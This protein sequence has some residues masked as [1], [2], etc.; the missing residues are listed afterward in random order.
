MVDVLKKDGWYR[1]GSSA[2][3]YQWR[4]AWSEADATEFSMPISGPEEWDAL[5]SGRTETQGQSECLWL[6][7]GVKWQ[8]EMKGME[9]YSPSEQRALLLNE[10][11]ALADPTECRRSPSAGRHG[12]VCA[13][14]AEPW[15][16]EPDQ[17][18]DQA[19]SPAIGVEDEMFRER[20]SGFAKK[21]GPL[22]VG[23]HV[24]LEGH[25]QWY[26]YGEAYERWRTEVV[27]ARRF[28]K[29]HSVMSARA[30]HLSLKDQ[31]SFLTFMDAK[32]LEGFASVLGDRKLVWSER[33]GLGMGVGVR[34]AFDRDIPS[35][36]KA[37]M[38]LYMSALLNEPLANYLKFE[39]F[40]A[41]IGRPGWPRVALQ[42]RQ[43]GLLGS[44]WWQAAGLLHRPDRFGLCPWCGLLFEMKHGNQRFC[45][46]SHAD[47]YSRAD[48]DQ[49]A[50]GKGGTP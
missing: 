15:C 49:R 5:V 3:R 46:S 4:H 22:G 37:L 31:W 41:P 50:A 8:N 2:R 19:W 6:T 21:W 48:M 14:C 40:A 44:M 34:E 24:L 23:E 9:R 27:R 10:L 35:G 18:H 12:R 16:R 33:L 32:Q 13:E 25:R 1:P 11:A 38:L 28:L 26:A 7:R 45:A 36:A 39:S 17:S 20:I 30:S 29:A 47:A 43:V 42:V